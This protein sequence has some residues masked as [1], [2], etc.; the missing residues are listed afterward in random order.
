[1]RDPD[2]ILDTGKE[3]VHLPM[4]E[5]IEVWEGPFGKVVR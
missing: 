3:T 4:N 5:L 1:V 2:I